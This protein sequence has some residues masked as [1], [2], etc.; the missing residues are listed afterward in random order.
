VDKR[1]KTEDV[2]GT[3]GSQFKDFGLSEE[4]QL[5]SK[6][7]ST[8]FLFVQGI[9]EMGFEAPSP[10]QE[11]SIPAALEGRNIVARAKNGTGKTAA[12]AIPLI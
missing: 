6:L 4:L 1:V 9:Y 12:Y 10:I 3:N 7:N 5:V 2:T 11:Q 8:N